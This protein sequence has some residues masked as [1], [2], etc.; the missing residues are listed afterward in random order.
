MLTTLRR[1]VQEATQAEGLSDV[2]ELIVNR[3]H[4]A[5]EVDVSSIYLL[6]PHTRQLKL[7]ASK[8]L[9]QDAIGQAHL[10]Q[11]QGL[12]GLVAERAEPVNL[13]DASQ[14]PKF[15]HFPK[16]GGQPLK[17][18]LG[19]PIL[20]R[21][22]LL[23]VLVIQGTREEQ[24]QEDHVAFLVTLAAQLAGAISSA[25][26]SGELAAGKLH[27]VGRNI[28]VNGIAGSPGIGI[29]TA[30][31]V[32]PDTELAAVPDRKPDSISEEIKL[33]R[34]AVARV[35]TD[36]QRIK[37]ELRGK[38]PV[39]D[40]ALFDAYLMMLSSSSLIDGAVER[41]KAGNWAPGA[42]R[43]TFQEY[44]RHFDDMD[45][46]YLRER[47][48]DIQDLGRRI[49]EQL[50][51][52]G[53]QRPQYSRRTVLVGQEISASQLAEVPAHLLVGLICSTGSGSSHVAILARA[54]GVPTVMG[55]T[56]L[57]VGR[58]DGIEVIVDGYQGSIYLQ[59]ESMVRTEFARLA[60]EEHELTRGLLSEAKQPAIT[61][62]GHTVP[63][64][65][66]SGLMADLMPA[67][68]SMADGIG[69]YRTEIPF[70][71]RERFPGEVEQANIYEQ[72]L[73]SFPSHPVTLRTLDVGGDK[74]LSYFPIVEDN[75]FLG[76]RGIRISLDHPDIFLTQLRAMLQASRGTSNL[77]VLFPMIGSMWELE[78]S[79]ELLK[80]ARSELQEEGM[81]TPEPRTGVMIEV[82]SAVYLAEALARKVDFLSVGTNDL[83][84]YLLAVDRNNT[85]VADLYHDDH[86]A[87]LGALQAIVIGAHRAG[88]PVSVC[89]EMASDPASMLLLLGIGVDSLSV[90]VASLPRIK[91]VIRS[92]SRQQ[93]HDIVMEALGLLDP[94]AIRTLL[95]NALIDAGLG[96]LVRAGKH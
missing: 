6:R 31:V 56:D 88:K 53:H 46:E 63:V 74:A 72:V 69:L 77:H 91:W 20:H 61:T 71:V 96:A 37:E 8:G 78:E 19:V 87:V 32:F 59:P 23:G 25:E 1:I 82:P 22:Q 50:L 16:T 86:P 93:A 24:F 95:N 51:T 9:P 81:E 26:I 92:F 33:F 27:A 64:Y 11:Y 80:R 14:H 29:G 52:D 48:T 18:F 70:M 39:E 90:S 30:V 3:V 2:L 65:I 76:Y 12:V 10:Q 57:P 35:E 75:P 73:R 4:E 13:S 43:A 47:S 21:R 54:L 94:V 49:L 58:I 83:V 15:R 68:R 17:S 7:M 42:L 89:G 36:L 34:E 44:Q 40:R 38:L 85:R 79:L 66:N 84:Q 60:R 28:M 45:D 62:D 67:Q 41:I 5:L 55:A